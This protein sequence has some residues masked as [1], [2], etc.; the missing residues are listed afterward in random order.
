V[1]RQPL[2]NLTTR[3]PHRHRC[4]LNFV[5]IHRDSSVRPLV[6]IDTDHYRHD[7]S[8]SVDV[9]G[10]SVDPQYLVTTTTTK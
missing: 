5:A 6:R 8:I 1:P 10:Q 2:V 4:Q 3:G 7:T 9:E